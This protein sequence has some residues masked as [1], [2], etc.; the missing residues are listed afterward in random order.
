MGF[1]P[2]A[3]AQSEEN[4]GDP[5]GIVPLLRAN[6]TSQ[7]A[8]YLAGNR[9]NLAQKL[10]YGTKKI[11]VDIGTTAPEKA[12]CR[13]KKVHA[14]R[15]QQKVVHKFITPPSFAPLRYAFFFLLSTQSVFV[16]KKIPPI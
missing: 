16:K 6:L 4:F 13:V 15:Q 2:N 7:S 12:W 5:L 1:Q 8:P 10:A 3:M 11:I 9:H 14:R